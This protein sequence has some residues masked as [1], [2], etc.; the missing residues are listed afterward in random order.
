[1]KSGLF[2]FTAIAIAFLAAMVLSCSCLQ[3]GKISSTPPASFKES[4]LIGQWEVVPEVYS[5]E[6]LILAEDH[7]FTQIYDAS[8]ATPPYHYEGQGT[9]S[10]EFRPSG[11]IYVYLEGMRYF[12][13]T[14][15]AAEN[16]NRNPDGSLILY[17]ERC[18]NRGITMQDK[19]ILTVSGIP[20]NRNFPRG[21]MLDFPK[22]SA[23][24]GD[25]FLHLIDDSTK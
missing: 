21:I 10:V 2:R 11:C 7:T 23:E 8:S 22:T 24:T 1:M 6:V 18:E 4:D 9:W 20:D 12:Y 25:T 19:V 13:L 5:H 16:G 3:P 14:E 17:G 15:S